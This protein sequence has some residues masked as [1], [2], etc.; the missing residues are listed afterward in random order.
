MKERILNTLPAGYDVEAPAGRTRQVDILLQRYRK[1]MGLISFMAVFVG[2][3]LIYNA[4][5]ISVVQRR[6]E[7]GILRA[8]GAG[9]GDIVRLFLGETL[10]VSVF[11]VLLGV[12]LGHVFAKLTIGVVA[13]SMT[14]C[15]MKT[16][17][18]EL[19]YS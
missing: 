14:E 15:Y 2:M 18:T 5:S 10:A 17:V 8:L 7:I 13:R 9:R 1:V 3:Y 12:G 6:K 16:S 4:V 11:G 19:A